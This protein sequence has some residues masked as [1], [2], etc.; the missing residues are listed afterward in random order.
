M[1]KKTAISYF[2]V[3]ILLA[4]TVLCLASCS[5]TVE[6]GLETASHDNTTAAE[7]PAA[8]PEI[9]LSGCLFIGDSRTEGL[10][11]TDSL[12]GA[13]VFCSVGMSVFDATERV[14]TTGDGAGYDLVHFLSTGNYKK[15][16]ILLGINEINADLDT[17]VDTYSS[18]IDLVRGYQPDAKIIIQANPHV[19]AWRSSLGDAY[20]NDN[21]NL[22]NEK[23]YALTDGISICWLDATPILD[24]EEGGLRMEYA[25]EDG[26]HPN[27]NCYVMWG[28]WIVLQNAH[29]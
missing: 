26:I 14:M 13:D 23:L 11:V 16:Y 27:R 19:T 28:D 10:R 15:V 25:E 5:L 2:A 21:V 7:Q 6:S 22:L 18:L 24:D 12:P 8:Q 29:Y 3:F 4:S 17:V 20:N 1:K 9:S